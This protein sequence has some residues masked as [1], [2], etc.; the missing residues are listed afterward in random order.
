[1]FYNGFTKVVHKGWGRVLTYYF[2]E[3]TVRTID[4]VVVAATA[5]T[6]LAAI[7]RTIINW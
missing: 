3:K 2:K 5:V 6:L 7:A 4:K 1:M